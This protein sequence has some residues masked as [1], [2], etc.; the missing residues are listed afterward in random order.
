MNWISIRPESRSGGPGSGARNFLHAVL[1]GSPWIRSVGE[2]PV[3]NVNTGPRDRSRRD[4]GRRLHQVALPQAHTTT[5]EEGSELAPAS[6]HPPARRRGPCGCSPTNKALNTSGGFRPEAGRAGVPPVLA[7][8]HGSRTDPPAAIAGVASTTPAPRPAPAVEARSARAQGC[9]TSTRNAAANSEATASDRGNNP[10][11]VQPQAKLL[12]ARKKA[13]ITGIR[14]QPA[15]PDPGFKGLLNLP[16][17][18]CTSPQPRTPCHPLLVHTWAE[19]PDPPRK[20]PPS[21]PAVSACPLRHDRQPTA[22]A[23]L[24]PCWR[25]PSTV[26]LG[27]ATCNSQLAGRRVSLSE[28]AKVASAGSAQRSSAMLHG[29]PSKGGPASCASHTSNG[30]HIPRAAPF[31]SSHPSAAAGRPPHHP[32]SVS[33]QA[34]G[35]KCP[36]RCPH[37]AGCAI[38]NGKGAARIRH[39][40]RWSRCATGRRGA[41]GPISPRCPGTGDAIGNPSDSNTRDGRTSSATDA[42]GDAKAS[43]GPTSRPSA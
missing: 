27:S 5:E 35:S 28:P 29:C 32:P 34:H 43:G 33:S 10:C 42:P 21:T 2:R 14:Q 17:V 12:G 31:R 20:R 22:R 26:L 37:P 24:R 38:F 36:T 1:A 15:R 7:G 23:C 30:I 9:W 8:V 3:E 25:P 41:P 13:A 16:G 11:A 19:R 40:H 6:R 39:R 18:L 4:S